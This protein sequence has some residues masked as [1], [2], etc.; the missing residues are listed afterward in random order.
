[1]PLNEIAD[2]ISDHIRRHKPERVICNSIDDIHQ[3]HV[4]VSRAT[5][6]ACRP[7]NQETVKELYEFKI[8]GSSTGQFNIASDVTGYITDKVRLMEYYKSEVKAGCQHPFSVDGQCTV[9]AADGVE[10]NMAYAELLR[11]VWSCNEF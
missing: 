5:R 11:M 3:D 8:P 9:N 1:M 6:I 4:V 10:Y 2:I 7:F